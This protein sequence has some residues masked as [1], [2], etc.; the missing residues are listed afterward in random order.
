MGVLGGDVDVGVLGGGVD[1]CGGLV[2]VVVLVD[3]EDLGCAVVFIGAGVLGGGVDGC[4][5]LF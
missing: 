4:G 3:V 5:R 2:C 1:G